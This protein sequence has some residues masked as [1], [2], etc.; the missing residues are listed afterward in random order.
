MPLPTALRRPFIATSAITG[1]HLQRASR[2]VCPSL[3]PNWH[4]VIGWDFVPSVAGLRLA[5]VSWNEQAEQRR[6][7]RQLT[8]LCGPGEYDDGLP[9]AIGESGAGKLPVCRLCRIGVGRRAPITVCD[10]RKIVVHW[11]RYQSIGV[12]QVG[13]KT[14]RRQKP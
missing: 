2:C 8:A 11:R 14:R 13:N 5:Q 12:L 7:G 10:S 4:Q 9:F 1:T 3:C 6:A